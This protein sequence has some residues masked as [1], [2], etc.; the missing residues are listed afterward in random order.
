MSV[1]FSNQLTP[2]SYPTNQRAILDNNSIQ[3]SSLNVAGANTTNTNSIDLQQS[4]PYPV[5]EIVN[6][7][8]GVNTVA[9]GLGPANSANTN[10]VLQTSSDN[11]NWANSAIFAT[12]LLTAASTNGA[13]TATVA[14]IKLPPGNARYIRAQFAGEATGGTPNIAYQG[15][16]QLLY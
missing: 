8:I 16:I 1:S 7:Q 14:N 10:A 15:T 2:N 9:N 12:P 5:T 3:V 4:T 11:S 6:V 13:V